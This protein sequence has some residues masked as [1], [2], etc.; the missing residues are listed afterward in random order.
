MSNITFSLLLFSLYIYFPLLSLKGGVSSRFELRQNNPDRDSFLAIY[1]ITSLIVTIAFYQFS[2]YVTNHQVCWPLVFKSI[3]PPNPSSGLDKDF[4]KINIDRTCVFLILNY[5]LNF[6]SGIGISYL[7]PESHISSWQRILKLNKEFKKSFKGV[8]A[9][10]RVDI[11]TKSGVCYSGNL[12]SIVT[13]KDDG[14]DICTLNGK[15][16]RF[17]IKVTPKIEEDVPSFKMLFNNA[18]VSNYNI[19]HFF[20]FEDGSESEIMLKNFDS[21]FE[22]IK[23]DVGVIKA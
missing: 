4:S 2:K 3:I 18:D 16:K 21:E 19:R 13:N 8:R 15:I 10:T 14:I 20:V 17:D 22:V 7:I 9:E 11:L 12:E 6:L 1:F 5:F 23:K